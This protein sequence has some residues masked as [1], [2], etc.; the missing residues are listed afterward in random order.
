MK[1]LALA[2]FAIAILTGTGWADEDFSDKTSF[3]CDEAT[4]DGEMNGILENGAGAR[5]G[6]K[7]IYSKNI[8]EVSRN[9]NELRCRVTFVMNTGEVSGIFRFW[10]QDV[11][12]LVR[13]LI[14]Q[15]R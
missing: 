4:I 15:R 7:L 12:S 8:S 5:N 2:A 10:N 9:T 11:H 1:R 3:V 6:V 14:G 13:F